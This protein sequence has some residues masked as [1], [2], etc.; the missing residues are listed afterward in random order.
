MTTIT[1][2]PYRSASIIE[3][4]QRRRVTPLALVIF[5]LFLTLT[6]CPS[7]RPSPSDPTRV[8]SWTGAARLVIDTVAW[9]IPAARLIVDAIVPQPARAVVDLALTGLS[10]ATSGLNDA[11]ASYEHR[12]ADQCVAHAAV[13]GVRGALVALARALA[14]SGIALGTTFERVA[15]SVGAIADGLVPRCA[16]DAGWASTGESLGRELQGIQRAAEVRGTVL[17]RDL[18]N[19][20]PAH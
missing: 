19:L 8:S 14:D 13:G 20:H 18:D 12:G 16:S 4:A 15:D 2:S 6:A 9:A 5:A 11:L 17:R 1:S 3:P 7:P 10:T